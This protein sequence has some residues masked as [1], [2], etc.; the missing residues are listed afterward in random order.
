MKLNIPEKT[1]S[2]VSTL[3]EFVIDFTDRR[4]ELIKQNI[5]N[6]QNEDYIPQRFPVVDFAEL[7]KKALAEHIFN[8]RLMLQDCS[9]VRFGQ[10][11][12]F[13]VTPVVDRYAA[14]LFKNNISEYIEL[15]RRRLSENKINHAMAR[16]L[17]VQAVN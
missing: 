16:E 15:Q 10:N 13:D 8:N 12:S 4:E 6:A 17:L 2:N 14:Q 3:L 9:T 11:G 1:I 7:M 5:R